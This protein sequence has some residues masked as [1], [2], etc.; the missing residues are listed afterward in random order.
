[1]ITSE[2]TQHDSLS[3]PSTSLRGRNPYVQFVYGTQ[4][5][6]NHIRGQVSGSIK[7]D[8]VK[9]KDTVQQST[10]EFLDSELEE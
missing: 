10:K 7:Y 2:I 9:E 4:P 6:L 8:T 3:W 1:M 5:I